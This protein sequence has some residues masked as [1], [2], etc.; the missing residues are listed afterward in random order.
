MEK[1]KTFLKWLVVTNY[2]RIVLGGILLLGG[3]TPL[4]WV[5]EDSILGNILFYTGL[6]G[7]GILLV[8]ALL[9]MVYAW[10]INP[11]REYKN[12]KK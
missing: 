3:F 5:D 4:N 12:K 9:M 7:G 6:T 1:L 10:I 8:Y 2:G 11:I